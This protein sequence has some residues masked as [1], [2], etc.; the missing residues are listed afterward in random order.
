M[1]YKKQKD[2]ITALQALSY[3]VGLC[4]VR[5]GSCHDDSRIQAKL[6]TFNKCVLLVL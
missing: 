3:L 5:H 2:V 4:V 1:K 6:D